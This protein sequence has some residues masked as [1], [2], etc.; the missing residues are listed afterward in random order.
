[1]SHTLNHVDDAGGYTCPQALRPI[2]NT[3]GIVLGPFYLILLMLVLLVLVCLLRVLLEPAAAF[4]TRL[5]P[6]CC[7]INDMASSKMLFNIEIWC[8]NASTLLLRAGSHTDA[9]CNAHC[10][11]G[12]DRLNATHDGSDFSAGVWAKVPLR[13][14]TAK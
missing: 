14:G 12:M 5:I 2:D 9:R 13:S 1:M 4:N 6:A 3:F 10:S 8:L 11:A 7:E